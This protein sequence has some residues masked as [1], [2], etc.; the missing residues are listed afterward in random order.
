MAEFEALNLMETNK[1]YE[2]LIQSRLK[3]VILQN[4]IMTPNL[5][6]SFTLISSGLLFNEVH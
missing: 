2:I 3:T 6:I 1:T 5:D 4:G